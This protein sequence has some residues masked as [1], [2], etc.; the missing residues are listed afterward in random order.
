MML[1][2]NAVVH[3]LHHVHVHFDHLPRG[4]NLGGPLH[5]PGTKVTHDG[6]AAP[7]REE[8]QGDTPIPA[9]K[10]GGIW[11]GEIAQRERERPHTSVNGCEC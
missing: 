7:P 4:H 11:G 2:G 1:P 10:R 8:A 5:V 3:R 6:I 9:I